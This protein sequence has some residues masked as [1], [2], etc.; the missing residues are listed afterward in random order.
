ME[1][2]ANKEI[3]DELKKLRIDVNILK[4]RLIDS[5]AVLT[6]EEE[7]ILNEAFDEYKRG[8]TVSLEEIEKS[9]KNA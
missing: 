6:I 3:L 5:D 7:G 1:Q 9:R 2:I 4:E 8:E